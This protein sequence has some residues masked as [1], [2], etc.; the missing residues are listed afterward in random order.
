MFAITSQRATALALALGLGGPAIANDML[1]IGTT[2]GDF[3]AALDA[4][5]F[6]PFAAEHGVEIIIVPASTAELTALLRAQTRAG[7]V[8]LDITTSNPQTILSDPQLYLE[9]DCTRIPNAA[10]NGVP[11]TCEDRRVLRT[12]GATVVAY[13]DSAFPDGGP[14]TWVDF[15]DTERFP[16]RRCLMGGTVE[17][18]TPF[19]IALLADGVAP[20]DLYPF[21]YER[22]LRKLRELRPHVSAFF[23]SYSMS[24][25][26]MRDGECVVSPLLD[27]R[28][29][30]LRNEGFSLS[31][32]I[33]QGVTSTGFWSIAAGT[34]N[35][36][37]AYAFL[38][39]W[40]TRPEAHSA[41]Y[42]V[43]NYATP[44]IAAADLLTEDEQQTFIGSEANYG[45]VL[46][47][48]ARWIAENQDEI[49]RTYARFLA[50]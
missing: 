50:E 23:T 49:A 8:E 12:V 17:T 14:Q 28:A 33:E 11:G 38:D 26:L 10:A 29:V 39:F 22:A 46:Q 40:M 41:F 31:Y 25:Q 6:A 44:L 9:L 5:F 19:I 43:I 4:N 27:G 1:V 3:A 16:G 15:F 7:Q 34:A 18:Y 37:L 24:Q 32:S 20:E 48:N 36:D 45:R 30:S 47:L 13:A 42:R 35:Q 21:D 2:G